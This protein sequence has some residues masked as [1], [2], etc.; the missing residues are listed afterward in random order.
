[1]KITQFY[2]L[3]VGLLCC[4]VNSWWSGEWSSAIPSQ[5]GK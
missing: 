4:D 3:C 2:G 1:M 5:V